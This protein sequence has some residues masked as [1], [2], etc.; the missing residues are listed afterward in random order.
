[1]PTVSLSSLLDESGYIE[2]LGGG[3]TGFFPDAIAKAGDT[4]VHPPLKWRGFMSFDSSGIPS[5]A[6]ITAATLTVPTVTTEL[7]GAPEQWE[8]TFAAADLDL[9]DLTTSWASDKGH[10]HEITADPPT[11]Y[12][13]D[14]DS[15]GPVLRNI[16]GSRIALK[17][18][19]LTPAAAANIQ[20]MVATATLALTYRVAGGTVTL[21]SGLAREVNIAC[22]LGSASVGVSSLGVESEADSGLATEVEAD[23][24][25]ATETETESGLAATV[26]LDSGVD[27]EE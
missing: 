11:S 24:G 17:L 14:C 7:G 1:M 25:L 22:G 21:Q 4:P 2:E 16:T 6:V 10:V 26:E 5:S 9:L 18:E 19:L 8:V 27:L 3:Y 20:P 23:S 12:T 15:L 13:V